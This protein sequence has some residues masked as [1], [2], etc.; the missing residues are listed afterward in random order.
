MKKILSTL[1]FA[2]FLTSASFAYEPI[3]GFIYKNTSEAGQGYTTIQPT[4]SAEAT[5]TSYFGIVGI[6]DCSVNTAAKNGKI[7]NISYYDRH[8]KN[9]LG[10]KKVTVKVYGN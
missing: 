7:K 3:Y 8:T 6:G 2:L 9:I 10:F 4:K 5:C 1:A